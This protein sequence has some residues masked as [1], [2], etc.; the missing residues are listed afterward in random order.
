MDLAFVSAKRPHPSI[1]SSCRTLPPNI[2][3]PYITLAMAVQSLLMHTLS[4]GLIYLI[5]I[6]PAT[7]PGQYSHL[8]VL[9]DELCYNSFG[10]L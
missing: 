10:G 3:I 9:H 7:F 2:N 1:M 6:G 5:Y 4:P 8:L